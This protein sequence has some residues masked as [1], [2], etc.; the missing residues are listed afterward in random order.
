MYP[1]SSDK[2]VIDFER[3]SS[4]GARGVMHNFQVPRLVNR[5]WNFLVNFE[6]YDSPSC[7]RR[8]SIGVYHFGDRKLGACVFYNQTPD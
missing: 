1:A 6:M 8:V 3:P 7:C 4:I 5:C 2:A